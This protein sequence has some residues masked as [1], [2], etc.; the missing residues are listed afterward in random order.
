MVGKFA[1]NAKIN[2]K[3]RLKLKLMLEL[4]LLIR[5]YSFEKNHCYCM[6]VDVQC[7]KVGIL[8]MA[9]QYLFSMP[10]LAL[11]AGLRPTHSINLFSSD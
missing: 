9:E 10:N 1:S 7:W 6:R 8:N 4:S 5:K 3:L 11:P 2:S